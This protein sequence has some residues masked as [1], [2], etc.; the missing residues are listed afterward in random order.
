[1][2]RVDNPHDIQFFKLV[3]VT[4]EDLPSIIISGENIAYKVNVMESKIGVL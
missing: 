2:M 1:M 3:P 4:E